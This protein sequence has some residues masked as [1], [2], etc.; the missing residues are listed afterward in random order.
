MIDS[1]TYPSLQTAAQNTR[2]RTTPSK[3]ATDDTERRIRARVRAQLWS[4]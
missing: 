1:R 4:R 3:T 2:P